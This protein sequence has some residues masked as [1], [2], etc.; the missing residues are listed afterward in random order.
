MEIQEFTKALFIGI[1]YTSLPNNHLE[2]CINDAYNMHSLVKKRCNFKDCRI[3]VDTKDS[4][5]GNL[6]TKS[7]IF[8][9]IK[10]L[11]DV[12]ENS[13]VFMHYSGHGGSV[14]DPTGK[15][16][17]RKNE[18][19]CNLDYQT[20]GEIIDDELNQMVVR[21][22]VENG[23]HLI[24]ITDSCHSG[25]N[26]DERFSM[27][28]INI[29]PQPQFNPP[30]LPPQPQFNPPQ[31][32]PQPQFN[33]PQ[34]NPNQLPPQLPPQLP[35]QPQFNPNQL[36]PQPHP[37]TPHLFPFNGITYPNNNITPYSNN[38]AMN[39]TQVLYNGKW[40]SQQSFNKL[41]VKPLVKIYKT[42]QRYNQYLLDISVMNEYDR[43]KISRSRSIDDLEIKMDKIRKLKN[44]PYVRHILKYNEI[45]TPIPESTRC[46]IDKPI[47]NY[48]LTEQ[49]NRDIHLS[50]QFSANVPPQLSR[51]FSANVPP[52]FMT[53]FNNYNSM[54]PYDFQQ[55]FNNHLYENYLPLQN[56]RV[57]YNYPQNLHPQYPSQSLRQQ[58]NNSS[59]SVYSIDSIRSDNKVRVETVKWASNEDVN[60][61]R[62]TGKGSIVKISGC[63]DF[64]T[65]AD[66][67]NGRENGALSGCLLTILEKSFDNTGK[68]IPLKIGELLYRIRKDLVKNRFEQIPQVCSNDPIDPDTYLNL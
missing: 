35:S 58:S 26:M 14:R 66:G 9:D 10:W 44:D 64:Q 53:D 67:Y 24:C 55:N 63:A 62:Y 46:L 12:P 33:P 25:S 56:Q 16:S 60:M 23:I 59:M 41:F 45:A 17:D 42:V 37:M 8:R 36:L 40:Y 18:T 11:L 51:Q 47:S 20:I 30:Q 4:P 6:P 15:E 43:I 1:N 19:L 7:N 31:L 65:S 2:N 21:T 39:N 13:Y 32:P 49:V 61:P 34:F 52:Q 28:E 22:V 48:E 50:R 27:K 5:S 3:L 68:P 57:F 29:S 38:V 54:V